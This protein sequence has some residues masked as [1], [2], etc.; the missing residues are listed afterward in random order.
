MSNRTINGMMAIQLERRDQL[1]KH[2]RTIEQDVEQNTMHQLIE[3]A[4][5]LLELGHFTNT[6]LLVTLPINWNLETWTHMMGK[7]YKERLVI[8]GALIAAE[9]DRL[10]YIEESK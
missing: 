7:P 5:A 10:N 2:G 1:T 6:D 3:A 9:I 8:A 4:T